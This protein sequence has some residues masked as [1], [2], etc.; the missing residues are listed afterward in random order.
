MSDCIRS[1]CRLY[2]RVLK[3]LS[4]IIHSVYDDPDTNPKTLEIIRINVV[5]SF[6]S[7]ERVRI[8]GPV[9]DSVDVNYEGYVFG[10]RFCMMS[11]RVCMDRKALTMDVQT[12][13]YYVP[14]DKMTP[15]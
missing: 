1:Q 12:S 8:C 6:E 14:M 5:R 13:G 9:E 15:L 4:L 7:I 10:Y 2:I 11:H 3:R